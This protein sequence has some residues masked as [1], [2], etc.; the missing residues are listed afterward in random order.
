VHDTNP[1]GSADQAA[2]QVSCVINSG[3]FDRCILFYVNVNLFTC[4]IRT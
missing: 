1:L 4:S 3:V 2:R